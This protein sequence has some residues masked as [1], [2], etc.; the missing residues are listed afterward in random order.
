MAA[1]GMTGRAERTVARWQLRFF[2]NVGAGLVPALL[3][4]RPAPHP[5]GDKPRPYVRLE[6]PGTEALPRGLLR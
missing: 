2:R 1:T 6:D 3:A 4:V 5:G